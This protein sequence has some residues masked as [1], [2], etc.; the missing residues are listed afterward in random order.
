LVLT[1]L[2]TLLALILV[3]AKDVIRQDG[4]GI[5]LVKNPSWKTELLWFYDTLRTEPFI[6]CLFPMFFA[7][8]WSYT[9]VF[10]DVNAVGFNT[11]TRALNNTLY[12]IME[13]VGALVFGY[14]LDR[15]WVRRTTRAKI[16]WPTLMA[17]T[18]AIWGG[19]YAFQKGHTRAEL[20]AKTFE[21]LDWKDSGYIGPMFL[22][23]FYGF[24]DAAWQ[25]SVYW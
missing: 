6:F 10:N 19:S 3:D 9:Y 18:M 7:S 4:S 12:Y 11:R 14:A 17:L 5:I 22:Y 21:M 20:A 8:T 13:I 2:G 15:P 25:T 1:I 23:M 24:F 16:L